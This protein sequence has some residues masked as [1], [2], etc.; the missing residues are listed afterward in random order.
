M[1]FIMHVF[2]DKLP[3]QYLL[4]PCEVTS[5]LFHSGPC[6]RS[7]QSLGKQYTRQQMGRST[8]KCARNGEQR[9]VY[10]RVVSGIHQQQWN[11]DLQHVEERVFVNIKPTMFTFLYKS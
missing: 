8:C 1:T 6:L 2:H 9:I 4:N 11:V 5:P 7:Q 10:Q 3:N